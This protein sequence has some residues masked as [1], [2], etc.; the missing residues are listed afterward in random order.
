MSKGD[1]LNTEEFKTQHWLQQ[2]C[3]ETGYNLLPFHEL[4]NFPVTEETHQICDPLPCFFPDDEFTAKAPD[5]VSK[6]LTAYGKQ[7]I[8]QNP[9]KVVFRGDLWRGVDE[10]GAQFVFQHDDEEC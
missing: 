2:V 9:R 6:I 5:K 1:A 8:R 10:R 7:C 3:N 4:W